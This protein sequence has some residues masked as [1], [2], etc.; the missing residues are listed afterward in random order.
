[1][2]KRIIWNIFVSIDLGLITQNCLSSK[3]LFWFIFYAADPDSCFKMHDNW[4]NFRAEIRVQFRH[5]PGNLYKG[6]FGTDLDRATNEL[7]IRVQPDEGI[8]LKIN[9][10]IPGL[11]MRLDRSN[12]N[13]HYAA[14]WDQVSNT[15]VF[16]PS[17]ICLFG[18]MQV[19]VLTL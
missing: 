2:N 15:F 5:V 8:Y 13:L 3:S 16:V 4:T 10:K 17:G 7:V 12:L 11:G 18:R 14:R 19:L 6:S 1:M 9:N